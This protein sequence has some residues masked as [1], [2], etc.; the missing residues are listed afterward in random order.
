MLTSVGNSHVWTI[1]LCCFSTVGCLANSPC[2]GSYM[3]NAHLD[4]EQG[5]N[6]NH[7][8][9]FWQKVSDFRK[10]GEEENVTVRNLTRN[11]AEFINIYS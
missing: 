8:I 6:S 11:V 2:Y 7:G 5:V 3:N 9:V 1:E 4:M 10:G